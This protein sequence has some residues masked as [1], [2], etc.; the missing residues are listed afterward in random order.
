M[1]SSV[2]ES[3]MQARISM[4]AL[5]FLLPPLLATNAEERRD[6]YGQSGH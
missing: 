4:W 2:I 6:Q 5:I 3:L 1:A